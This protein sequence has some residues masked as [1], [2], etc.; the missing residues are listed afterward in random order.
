MFS[1]VK[2]QLRASSNRAKFGHFV[3]RCETIVKE[4]LI[5]WI[6]VARGIVGSVEQLCLW[7]TSFVLFQKDGIETPN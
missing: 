6:Q 5:V 7:E 1:I 2:I 3:Y 4:M